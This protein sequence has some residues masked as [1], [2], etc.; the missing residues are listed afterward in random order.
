MAASEA[1]LPKLSWDQLTLH[2]GVDHRWRDTEEQEE[3]R[4]CFTC[5]VSWLIRSDWCK[6]LYPWVSYIYVVANKKVVLVEGHEKVVYSSKLHAIIIQ[7]HECELLYLLLYLTKENCVVALW[8]IISKFEKNIHSMFSTIRVN[9]K[10]FH[11]WFS[12]L[13]FI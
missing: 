5:H 7:N 3:E 13:F 4:Q 12:S 9:G 1:S 8:L 2:L 10:I 6:N 11:A